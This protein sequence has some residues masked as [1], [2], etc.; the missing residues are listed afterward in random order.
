MRS[1]CCWRSA[2]SA[3]TTYG[4]RAMGASS[5]SRLAR[6]AM[7]SSPAPSRFMCFRSWS[8]SPSC[9]GLGDGAFLYGIAAG[10]GNRYGLAL[11]RGMLVSPA[12][13]HRCGTLSRAAAHSH[14]GGSLPSRLHGAVAGRRMAAQAAGYLVQADLLPPLGDAVWD[15]VGGVD[16]Q[17]RRR[18][19]AAHVDRLRRP[20]RRHP[21][22]VLPRHPSQ[23]LAVNEMG[24]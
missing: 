9:A 22:P 15:N 12:G 8:A 4:C 19:G 17:Q 16:R 23:H 14:S 10:G 3:G 20:A 11:G 24:G 13:R 6:S 21:D 1:F 5:P 18:Q 7:R 2:C